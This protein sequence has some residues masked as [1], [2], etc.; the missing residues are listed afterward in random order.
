MLPKAKG[1]EEPLPEGLFWLL[2]TGEV[3]TED[4]VC[5]CIMCPYHMTFLHKFIYL[6]IPPEGEGCVKGMGRER[7][8]AQSRGSDVEQL[9]VHPPSN[10]PV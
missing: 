6:W 10:E 3:P 8:F 4:Q 2:A 9:S 7:R 5:L 1:G